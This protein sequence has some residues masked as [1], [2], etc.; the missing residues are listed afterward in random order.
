MPTAKALGKLDAAVPVVASLATDDEF[1]AIKVHEFNTLK[2]RICK[3]LDD[4]SC[5][6]YQRDACALA[7]FQGKLFKK[8]QANHFSRRTAPSTSISN[9]IAVKTALAPSVQN[10]PRSIPKCPRSIPK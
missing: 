6:V 9:S 10:S 4:K 5:L 3:R 1:N 8:N 7:V 2:R